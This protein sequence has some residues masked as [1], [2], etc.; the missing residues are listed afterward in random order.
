M[1]KRST[2]VL[3]GL[4]A[5]TV[6]ASTTIVLA[7]GGSAEAA[8]PPPWQTGP[9]KDPNNVG[10][11]T[12]HDASGATVT[13]GTLD[14]GPIADFVAGSTA[15]RSGDT[16]A[17]LFAYTPKSGA[18]VGSWS[19][20]QLSG[21]TNFDT[22]T[23]PASLDN[24]LPVVALTEADTTL[25]QY[26]AGFPNT[27]STAGY[28]GV[29]ELRLRTT[30]VG[31]SATPTYDVVDIVIDG[32]TW[33]IAGVGGEATSTSLAV[34]PTSPAVGDTATLSATVSPAVPGTVQFKDGATTLG[35]PV[36][37]SSGAASTTTV[38]AKAGAHTYSAVFTPTDTDT[39]AGSTGDA[40]VTV[41]KATSTTTATWPSSAKYGTAASAKV[42]V[43]ASAGSPTGSVTIKSGSTTVGTGTLSGGVATVKLSA[44]ALK[45]GSHSLTATYAGN[46]DVAGSTSTAGTLK[47][48]K[49]TG[50]LTNKLSASKIKAS[51]KG[52]LTV[53]ATATG[54]VPAGTVTI[55][56]GKK[57]IGTAKL[58]A[59]KVVFTLPKL[60]KGTHKI[61]AV[62]AGSSLVSAATASTVTLKV[63]K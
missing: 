53:K 31:H 38:I 52:K 33:H 60:K 9:D 22:A 36:A 14:D 35:A 59:G 20:L 12:L 19:G 2:S 45:P 30:S 34:A 7:L 26:A 15:L 48:A 58:K 8:T 10:V 6:A 41:A 42:T 17:T 32:N 29:Y 25:P 63:V 62:Y 50:K 47:V 56:D 51:A 28:Q 46:A 40:S 5:A 23:L 39:Y 13:S 49:A 57:K 37:V 11:L 61:H 3:A 4:T 1:T 55:Y 18:P 27:S 44:T 21:T 24:G 16:F 54:T 43:A